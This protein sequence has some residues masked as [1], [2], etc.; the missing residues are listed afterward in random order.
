MGLKRPKLTKREPVAPSYSAPASSG[1]AYVPS[2]SV[3]IDTSARGI[4]VRDL[5]AAL[6]LGGGAPGVAGISSLGGGINVG[7][8]GFAL[9]GGGSASGNASVESTRHTSYPLLHDLTGLP[10]K[11]GTRKGPRTTSYR[12]PL[13]RGVQSNVY[14]SI[15]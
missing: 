14:D 6:G 11:A 13:Q 1:P 3:D 5:N 2:K 15:N 10:A 9:T 4:N 8:L 7:D 12:I